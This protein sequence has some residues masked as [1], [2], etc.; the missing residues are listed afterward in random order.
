MRKSSPDRHFKAQK[1]QRLACLFCILYV[2]CV[3]AAKG[4]DRDPVQFFEQIAT[5][6]RDNRL[7]E[8]EKE[9]SS[10]L[11]VSPELPVA[12][13]LLG[14]VR[15]KQGR[16]VEAETLF[17]RAARNDKNFTGARM[18]LVYLYLL[19]HAPEKSIVQLKEILAVEPENAEAA[20]K[21][22]DLLVSQGRFD[23]CIAFVEKQK[24]TR[25]VP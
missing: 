20:E 15:A 16:L 8:A 2:F 1:V 9:L 17:L 22:T 11:R 23:E 25:S 21:L 24:A 10:V 6:I 18:N 13:N 12:L 19:K 7:K 5:L 3:P 4:Q 14:T